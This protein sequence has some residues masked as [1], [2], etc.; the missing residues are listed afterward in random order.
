MLSGNPHSL[1]VDR[2]WNSSVLVDLVL[3]Q[4]QILLDD[5][6]LVRGYWEPVDVFVGDAEINNDCICG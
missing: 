1:G 3:D 5:A 4:P 2:P 6:G